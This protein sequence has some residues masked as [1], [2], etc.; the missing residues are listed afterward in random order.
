MYDSG[1]RLN[2]TLYLQNLKVLYSFLHAL[3]DD[4]ILRMKWMLDLCHSKQKDDRLVCDNKM[5]ATPPI[6]IIDS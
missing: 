1:P 6:I 2:F 3:T 4:A 5:R